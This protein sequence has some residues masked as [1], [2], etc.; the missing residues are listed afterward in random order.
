MFAWQRCL[1]GLMSL[2]LAWPAIAAEPPE[3]QSLFQQVFTRADGRS[4]IPFPFTALLARLGQELAPGQPALRGGL[5]LVVIPLGRSLQRH[6]AE[7]AGYFTY[8]RVV[9]AV[10][11]EPR[12][13]APLLKDRLYIGYHELLGV[14][15]VISYNEA[16]GRFE[17][18][19]VRDYRPGATPRLVQARRELCLACHHNGAPIFARQTWDE[20]AASPAIARL[21]EGSLSPSLESL[22]WRG[23]VDIPNAIDDATE[24]ANRL[25]LA[26]RLWQEGCG[27]TDPAGRAC[28]GA[29]L[30]E[31]L[32]VRL[33][34]PDL[35]SASQEPADPLAPLLARW[36]EGLALPN[37]D[38][39]NRLPLAP[40]DQ[41]SAEHPTA[42]QLRRVAD[43]TAPFDPLALRPPRDTWDPRQPGARREAAAAVSLFLAQGDVA[44]VG[45]ALARAAPNPGERGPRLR[46][47][48]A[49]MAEEEGGAL[50]PGPLAR[51]RVVPALLR[52]LGVADV[53][54]CGRTETLS[55]PPAEAL[56]PAP[57]GLGPEM[58]ALFRACGACHDSPDPFPPGFLRGE[59]D[60]L[61][62][63]VRACA[64]RMIHRLAMGT[65]PV[66]ARTK[67]P[68]PPPFSAHGPDFAGSD[69]YRRLLPWLESLA[70]VRSAVLLERPYADLPP[71][72][73]A[74]H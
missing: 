35:A 55:P 14:L 3:G 25:G 54:C 34:L 50:G 43:V 5:P 56:R 69:D 10:T 48:V 23:G 71:C 61:P 16:A 39:P 58:A 8:P 53:R 70:G 37:P 9:L 66:G 26:Q 24:R 59:G 29:L 28:R 65:L 33:G 18:Q 47:A 21:L 67:A 12:P 41:A 2:V 32:L 6:A 46:R 30:T 42:A 4:E 20:T 31:A 52:Q 62:S 7:D 13:G 57:A 44:A 15:E 19:L 36:P 22:P 40:L 51:G 17:F 72:R 63:Q 45:R 68:M 11:G 73:P 64:P 74:L 49:A 27:V 60:A 1:P 38:V